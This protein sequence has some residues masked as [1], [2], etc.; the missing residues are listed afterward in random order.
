[1]DLNTLLIMYYLYYSVNILFF[2]IEI[3]VFWFYLCYS[4]N[5][6]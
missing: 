5:N 4:V 6:D 3:V 1:M 2:S